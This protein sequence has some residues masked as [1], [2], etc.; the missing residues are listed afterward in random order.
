[1][2]AVTFRKIDEFEYATVSGGTFVPRR[3]LAQETQV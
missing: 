2:A 1:M 3:F